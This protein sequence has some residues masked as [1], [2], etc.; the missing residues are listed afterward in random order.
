MKT[1]LHSYEE[2]ARR[3][4]YSIATEQPTPAV[5]P[6][7]SAAEATALAALAQLARRIE[8]RGIAALSTH[9]QETNDLIVRWI[10]AADQEK[11]E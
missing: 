11:D 8:E 3:L 4:V 10:D 5:L 7:I 1:A 6:D 2:D 9:W